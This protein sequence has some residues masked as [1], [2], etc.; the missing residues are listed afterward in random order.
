MRQ[1][2]FWSGWN[3]SCSE[4]GLLPLVLQEE[5]GSVLSVPCHWVVEVSPEPSLL[6]AGQI[7]YFQLLLLCHVLYPLHHPGDPPWASCTLSSLLVPN[8]QNQH[9]VLQQ[10]SQSGEQ[11]EVSPFLNRLAVLFHSMQLSLFTARTHCWLMFNWLSS[12]IFIAKLLPVQSFHSLYCR[13][14]HLL[15]FGRFLK[16]HFFSPLRCLWTVAVTSSLSAVLLG[17]L[18]SKLHSVLLSR[19]LVKTLNTIGPH[20]CHWMTSLVTGHQLDIVLLTTTF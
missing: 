17:F 9:T 3:F 2:V 6:K 7:L 1:K 18:W 11:R 16:A 4:L 14:L 15:N 5:C 10:W 12:Q 13:Y 20:V 19:A 8:S